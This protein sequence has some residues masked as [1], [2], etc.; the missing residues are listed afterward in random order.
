MPAAAAA[1]TT[2]AVPATTA[3]V[4]AGFTTGQLLLAAIVIAVVARL[5]W[6]LRAT[7]IAGL[8]RP[9]NE[10]PFFGMSYDRLHPPA[11]ALRIDPAFGCDLGSLFYLTRHRMEHFLDF[12]EQGFTVSCLLRAYVVVSIL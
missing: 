3:A 1:A 8:P 7:H 12:L 6:K 9:T 2:A 4:A 5:L 11:F 10:T